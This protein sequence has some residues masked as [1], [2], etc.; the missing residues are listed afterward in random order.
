[1]TDTPKPTVVL[2]V[3]VGA[4]FGSKL[5]LRVRSSVLTVVLAVVLF[6]LFPLSNR[7]LLS[8]LTL[9][10]SCRN[11]HEQ[12]VQLGLFCRAFYD[13]GGI[14]A[15]DIGAICYFADPHLLDVWGLGTLELCKARLELQGRVNPWPRISFLDGLVRA[16]G[17][18]A[19]LVY[20]RVL[21]RFGAA[22]SVGW[23][24]VGSWTIEHNIVCAQ[25]EVAF[26]APDSTRARRLADALT[27][28]SSALPPTVRQAGLAHGGGMQAPLPP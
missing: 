15:N 9:P 11:I 2:G 5:T 12:Q 26:Y 16:Q 13:E 3:T 21:G 28:F 23:I 24:R 7:A 4:Y 22:D 19:I 25:D 18:D 6:G 1:M 10:T 8:C 27:R 14:A 20:D 17:V